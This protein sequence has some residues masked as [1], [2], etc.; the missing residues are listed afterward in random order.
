MFVDDVDFD[1]VDEHQ[2]I[3]SIPAPQEEGFI[4]LVDAE[5]IG[6]KDHPVLVVELEDS[7]CRTFRV[8]PSW[9]WSVQNNLVLCNM[10]WEDFA[11]QVDGDGIFRGF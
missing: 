6:H 9:V 4:F 1:G 2:I 7:T 11:Y 3:E 10:D 5:T 8:V